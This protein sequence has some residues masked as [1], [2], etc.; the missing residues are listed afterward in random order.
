MQAIRAFAMQYPEVEA[1]TSCNKTAFRTRNKAFLFMGQKD[2][3][4]NL[5]LKLRDSEDEA[6]LLGS[7]QT[8]R[9][10]VGSH[11]WVTVVLPENEF[12]PSGLLERWIDES[13][14]LL[15]HK[16]LV[17]MLPLS[18]PLSLSPRSAGNA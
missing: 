4:Y 15:A 14:R 13:Y 8:G 2:G 17:A 5:M 10:K 16:K 18:D 1:G 9:Y 12:P 3:S 6:S 7:K 11:G